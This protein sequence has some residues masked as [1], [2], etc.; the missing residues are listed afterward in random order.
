MDKLISIVK[1]S[2]LAIIVII[3]LYDIVLLLLGYT[4]SEAMGDWESLEGWWIAPYFGS[5]TLGHW[6]IHLWKETNWW[7]K[8][9]PYRYLVLVGM[10]VLTVVLNVTISSD[11]LY[12]P[13]YVTIPGG[14]ATGA[15]LWPQLSK[16]KQ[17]GEET[18][19][20]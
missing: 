11:V 12:L 10:G 13:W 7:M 4:I 6:H 9:V 3:V 18:K 1:W 14:L 2:I 15:L 16:R 20:Q 17:E 8:W 5:T 19:S